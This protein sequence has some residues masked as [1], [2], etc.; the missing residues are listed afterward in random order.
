M[1]EIIINGEN[2]LEIIKEIK[3]IILNRYP[4]LEDRMDSL[5][6]SQKAIEINIKFLSEK[7]K[8]ETYV[9]F[10]D[11]VEGFKVATPERIQMNKLITPNMICDLIEFIIS[12]H[13]YVKGL[14]QSQDKIELSFGVDMRDDNMKGME[15]QTIELILDF[16]YCMDKEEL[17]MQYLKEII[18]HFASQLQ[19][20]AFV[21]KHLHEYCCN[22]K[23]EVINSLASE[24]LRS[25]IQLL[26]DEDLCKLLLTLSDNEFA[27]L[28]NRFMKQEDQKKQFQ[29]KNSQLVKKKVPQNKNT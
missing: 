21:Q 10:L 24:E 5:W 6:D 25:F 28:Y 27:N 29:E 1:Q 14:N 7:N 22:Q 20:T 8:A 13:D 19:D 11:G 16:K 23:A 9:M 2:N 26:S 15:C 12:D 17:I 4:I 18:S 3:K